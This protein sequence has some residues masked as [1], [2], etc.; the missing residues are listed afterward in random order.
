[1]GHCDVSW[2]QYKDLETRFLRLLRVLKL[3]EIPCP[4]PQGSHYCCECEDTG[5]LL[6]KEGEKEAL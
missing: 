1:M 4:N 2:E 3:K 6:V 5:S